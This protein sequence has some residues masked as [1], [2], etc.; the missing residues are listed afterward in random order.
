MHNQWS[1]YPQ[2]YMIKIN[3]TFHCKFSDSVSRDEGIHCARLSNEQYKMSIA[4]SLP[5]KVPVFGQFHEHSLES[6]NQNVCVK[7]LYEF[8]YYR[9]VCNVYFVFFLARRTAAEYSSQY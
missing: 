9:F 6:T 5:V 7:Y 4:K 2:T 3:L 1:M 8:D